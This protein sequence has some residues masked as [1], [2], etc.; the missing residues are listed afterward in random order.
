RAFR[1]LGVDSLTALEIRQAMSAATG[2]RLPA[3][4]LFDYPTPVVLAGYLR[5]E[6]AGLPS[7]V[8]AAA[9]LAAPAAVAGDPVAIVGM[10]CRFPGGVASPEELWE[11]LTAGTDAISGF[12]QDRGWEPGTGQ[13]EPGYARMGGFVYEASEFDAG[14]VGI[15]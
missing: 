1:D 5:A 14:F 11:L 4:L 9:D 12:P 8:A 13:A 10:G 7:A 15:P 6:L 2:L 3:T